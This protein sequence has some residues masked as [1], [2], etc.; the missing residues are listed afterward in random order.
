MIPSWVGFPED[1]SEILIG[2]AAK[3]QAPLNPHNTVYDA[4]RLIGR[5]FNDAQLQKDIKHF[6][7]K[8]L[9]DGKNK[10]IIEVDYQGKK[11]RYYPEQISAMVLE[12]LKKFAIDYLGQNVTQAVVT[13]PAY[14]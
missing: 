3:T 9:D 8:V 5:S 1:G 11:Q 12:R 13:V 7:F 4:K 14:L 6:P 10:P 2:D